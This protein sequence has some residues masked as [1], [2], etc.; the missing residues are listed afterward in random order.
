MAPTASKVASRYLQAGYEPDIYE[1]MGKAHA[2]LK[3]A[4][5]DAD[6]SEILKVVGPWFAGVL[7]HTQIPK[8]PFAPDG[9]KR[10]VSI[11]MK[12]H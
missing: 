10:V 3:E 8:K 1:T 12:F 7:T 11:L 2:A 6:D 5:P 4:Y 9:G